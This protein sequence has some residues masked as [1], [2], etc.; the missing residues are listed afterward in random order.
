MASKA[1]EKIEHEEFS[2]FVIAHEK[3]FDE[4]VKEGYKKYKLAT[5]SGSGII[6]II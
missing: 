3:I 4:A 5:K 2:Q 1:F 6:T